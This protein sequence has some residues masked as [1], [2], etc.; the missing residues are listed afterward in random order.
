MPRRNFSNAIVQAE[1]LYQRTE[2]D[3]NANVRETCVSLG[4]QLDAARNTL[5]TATD[6]KPL[7]KA[8]NDI[9]TLSSRLSRLLQP[10]HGTRQAPILSPYS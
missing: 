4:A 1:D 10:H 8:T 9:N 5:H 6:I 3:A 7:N 2:T